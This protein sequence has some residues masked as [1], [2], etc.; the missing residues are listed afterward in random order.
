M[1]AY[2]FIN[3][4]FPG[5]DVLGDVIIENNHGKLIIRDG[6]AKLCVHLNMNGASDWKDSDV[7]VSYFEEA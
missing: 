5:W 6:D 2:N 4:Y 7:T 1:S 3:E